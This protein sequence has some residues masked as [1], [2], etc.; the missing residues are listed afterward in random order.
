MS[1]PPLFALVSAV[2]NVDRYLTEFFGSLDAQ[3]LDH[4]RLRIVLVDDGSED[5]SAERCDEWANSTDFDVT[6][7]RVSNGGQGAARNLGLEEV[8]DAD[9]VTFIDPD[10]FVDADY[11]ERVDDFLSAN[12]GIELVSC[13][14]QDYREDLEVQRDRHPLRYRYADGDRVIDL[15]RFPNNLQLSAATAFFRMASLTE[16]GLNFDARVQP[17]FED[18]HLVAR[19]LLLAPKP[20]VA[21]LASANYHYRRRSDGSSTIQTSGADPRRYTTV[22]EHGYLAALAF[23]KDT[24]GH[25]PV[26][27]QNTVIYDLSWT[28]R[29]D[30]QMLSATAGLDSAS[31]ARFHEL[32]AQC[33][34]YL[35]DEVIEGFDITARSTTQVEAL[36]HGYT[37]RPWRWD[38]VR[39][40]HV[41][42]A[43]KLVELRYHFT[44]EQPEE[45]LYFRGNPI[46]PIFAKTRDHVYLQKTLVRERI[47]W[48]SATGTLALDLDGRRVELTTAWPT[49]K[50]FTLPPAAFPKPARPSNTVARRA[51][52]RRKPAPALPA[53]ARRIER[54]AAT[55]PVRKMFKNAWVLMDRNAN[56]ND[57][58][59]HLFRYLRKSRRDINAWFV[60]S[61]DSDDYRRLKSEG[62]RRLVPFGSLRW[63]LLTLNAEYVLS[64]HAE[65]YVYLPF[66]R[67]KPWDWKFIFLQH[68]VTKDDLSRWLNP[69]PIAG[70]ITATTTEYASIAGNGS[71]YRFSPHEV[72]LTGF[73]R[74]DRLRA[75]AAKAER[76]GG[77]KLLLVMPTWRHYVVG[78]VKSGTGEHILSD[79]MLNSEFLAAWKATLHSEELLRTASALGAKIVF[80]PHP[81]LV[82]Y[83]DAFDVPSHVEVRTYANSNIQD[84]LAAAALVLTDYSSIAFDAAAIRRKVVYYQFDRET[85]FSGA[86]TTRPGYFDYD[87][88]GFGP[89]A[90]EP[91][92]LAQ[93]LELATRDEPE[94]WKSYFDRADETFG[95]AKGSNSRRVVDFVESLG[96]PVHAR[97]AAGV[98]VSP[99][100]PAIRY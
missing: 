22:V 50:R 68:G 56:A 26:W 61:P 45:T 97:K 51:K 88:H 28:L 18:G 86:H 92:G 34:S 27:L 87:D 81:N 84:M 89:I 63:K 38:A 91:E 44:G 16:H 75:V 96:R 41:D 21:F 85:V 5:A 53:R 67:S 25:V 42:G 82:D 20:I 46:Q 62:Y 99:E 71:P 15:D 39:L 69:K 36:L 83:I 43:R 66:K 7:L 32:V 1:H 98:T 54:L 80:V 52:R 11:F 64:S 35:D 77:V 78:E 12:E 2:Y 8:R 65:R 73:P 6:V 14:Q 37:E 47:F 59:E 9:W 31:A 93:T 33:R 100:A 19:Y 40:N 48:V 3:S 55:A 90:I 72:A 57:N 94:A 95:V 58:A 29:S 74:F 76:S 24:K 49:T 79:A 70:L 60:L 17:N 30:E 23:A 10:D 13:H 4:S